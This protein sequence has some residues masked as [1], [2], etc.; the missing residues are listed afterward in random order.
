M[1]IKHLRYFVAVAEEQSF[2]RAAERLWVAQPGL[3]Q[4]IRALER[5]LGAQLFERL[6][7]G[8][9]LTDEG[10]VFLAKARVALTAIEEALATGRDAGAGQVGRVRLG[11]TPAVR[12]GLMIKLLLALR[13]ERPR[14]AVSVVEAQCGGLLRDVRDARLDA[15]IVLGPV[16]EPRLTAEQIGEERA[17][18]AVSV[19]DPLSSSPAV[20]PAAIAARVL[21]VSG[22]PDAAAYDR[23]VL[24]A[25][26]DDGPAPR[27][28]A[29]GHLS[30]VLLPAQAGESVSIVPASTRP[31]AGSVLR[32]LE[33]D[34]RFSFDLVW[35]DDH[36]PPIAP[37]LLLAAAHPHTGVV[38]PGQAFIRTP[39]RSP[40]KSPARR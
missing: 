24:Q 10:A 7:R 12:D 25:L 18:A 8:V 5:E 21:T 4:Q 11:F 13:E 40:G 38:L 6:N 34:V 28:L 17:L 37:F 36:M 9:A 33:R 26:P 1:E 3:S 39:T 29:M 27:R 30:T 19:D 22:D 32:P 16:T 20:D 14:I 2:T 15:A 35:R 31:L 23:V